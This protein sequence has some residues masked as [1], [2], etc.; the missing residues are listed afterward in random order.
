MNPVIRHGLN[1]MVINAQR[2]IHPRVRAQMLTDGEIKE[3]PEIPR[4]HPR[5]TEALTEDLVARV[6]LII[7]IGLNTE[8]RLI[9]ERKIDSR[10]PGD[11]N[12]VAEFVRMSLCS[13]IILN[14]IVNK[15]A[16]PPQTGGEAKHTIKRT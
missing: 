10:S 4:S 12:H 2:D 9:P 16:F 8:G 1:P 3:R 13:Q 11:N 15:P 6:A 14:L 7:S 5:L